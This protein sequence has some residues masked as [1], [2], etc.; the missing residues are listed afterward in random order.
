MGAAARGADYLSS[1][2]MPRCDLCGAAPALPKAAEMQPASIPY[3]PAVQ[4]AS[5]E[6]TWM[7]AV[8]IAACPMPTPS[9]PR[10]GMKGSQ[11]AGPVQTFPQTAERQMSLKMAGK[12]TQNFRIICV[13]LEQFI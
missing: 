6:G 1:N 10:E 8:C 4:G 12:S 9:L 7:Q 5:R 2:R 13:F 3:T 11:A